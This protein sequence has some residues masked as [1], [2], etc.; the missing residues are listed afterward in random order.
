MQTFA[1]ARTYLK[2][3]DYLEFCTICTIFANECK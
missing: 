2:K 1:Y 3:I